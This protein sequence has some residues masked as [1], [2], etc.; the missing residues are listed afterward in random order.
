MGLFW[1]MPCK[2]CGLWFLFGLLTV[3]IKSCAGWRE[4]FI[5][6]QRPPEISEGIKGLQRCSKPKKSI[7]SDRWWDPHFPPP[8]NRMVLISYKR[9]SISVVS[10]FQS[11]FYEPPNLSVPSLGFVAGSWGWKSFQSL[12]WRW[13]RN[14]KFLPGKQKLPDPNH[15]FAKVRSCT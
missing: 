9:Q 6:F 8:R 1:L 13:R 5:L 7:K 15:N 14:L 2:V 11:A 12:E 10:W 3:P 4:V